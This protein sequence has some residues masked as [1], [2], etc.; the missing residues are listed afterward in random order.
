[1]SSDLLG[2]VSASLTSNYETK[3]L[4]SSDMSYASF[5]SQYI[6]EHEGTCMT[7][8]ERGI[9]LARLR[10]SSESMQESKT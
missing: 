2:G 1:M 8:A 4:L 6:R 7:S 3:F 5:C 9:I 10:T